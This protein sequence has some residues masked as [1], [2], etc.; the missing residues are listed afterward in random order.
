MVPTANGNVFS[1]AF[2]SAYLN[3][4]NLHHE[5]FDDTMKRGTP[6]GEAVHRASRYRFEILDSL[7]WCATEE[8]DYDATWAAREN[9]I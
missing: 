5:S 6:I 2:F 3:Q 7:R 1:L 4:T 9:M 8:A